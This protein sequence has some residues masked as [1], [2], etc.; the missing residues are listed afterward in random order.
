MTSE[1]EYGGPVVT[2]I[3]ALAQPILD[4]L[5]L[6]L[7]DCEHAGGTLIIT[8]DKRRDPVGPGSDESRIGLC[9]GSCSTNCR[10]S[11]GSSPV[12]SITTTR[13]PVATR[14]RC[15]APVSNGAFAAPITTRVRSARPSPSVWFARST[16]RG[17]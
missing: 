11:P 4:D 3:V 15:R 17:A 1:S 10:C 12:S 16:G 14:S 5:G 13:C 9:P 8:L 6:T 7:Y 2:R